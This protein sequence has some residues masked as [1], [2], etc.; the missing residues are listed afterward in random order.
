MP[1]CSSSDYDFSGSF[2]ILPP[3]QLTTTVPN[4][5][6]DYRGGSE[7]DIVSTTSG[8][9]VS[10]MISATASWVSYRPRI[11]E[12]PEPVRFTAATNRGS[13]SRYTRCSITPISNEGSTNC[14]ATELPIYQGSRRYIQPPGIYPLP[15][16]F[17]S[18]QDESH[19][20]NADGFIR[21]HSKQLC[22]SFR[23]ALPIGPDYFSKIIFRHCV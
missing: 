22:C 6:F 20:A 12:T 10:F 21:C 3:H 16:P 9:L 13:R 14:R 5:H 15:S 7:S 17:K 4:L 8:I 1:L 19:I 11:E 18:M 2:A 23:P